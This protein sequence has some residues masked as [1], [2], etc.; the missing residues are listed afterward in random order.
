M[1]A[2]RVPTLVPATVVAEKGMVEVAK[3]SSPLPSAPR[4][5]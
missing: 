5:K 1:E 2:V 4:K 3:A